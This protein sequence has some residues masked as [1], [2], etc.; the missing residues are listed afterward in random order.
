MRRWLAVGVLSAVL[1]GGGAAA[2]AFA[3]GCGGVVVPEGSSATASQERAI[4]SY[5]GE[6]ETIELT[7]DVTADSPSV[8]LIIPT[9]GVAS[10]TAGDGRTFDLIEGTIVSPIVDTV[11]WW[12]LGYLVPDPPKPEPDRLS[13]VELGPL[14][15]QSFTADDE[16][17]LNAWLAT[18][19][20]V[21]DEKTAKVLA[22]YADLGWSLTTVTL[23]SEKALSG[24]IDPIRLEFDTAQMVY[25]MR[26]NSISSTPQELRLYVFDQQRDAITLA[27]Q[28]TV[29]IDGSVDVVWSGKVTDS[30]LTVFGPYLTVFDVRYE[31]PK[32]DVNGDLG[33]VLSLVPGDEKP[34]V[35]HYKMVTLLGIPVG[36][37]IV[38]WTLLGLAIVTGHF[39][40]RRRAR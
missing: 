27:G 29:G 37:L 3:C 25:P 14:V 8:G 21:V 33:F 36:T 40:G 30:R 1:V 35:T 11:D 6:R 17:S 20:Y 10:V 31:V 39:V 15:A 24:H 12:G 13:R 5:D 7:I 16:E 9:P 2:P 22:Q 18:T 23:D 4:I 28:P 34:T 26:L 38:G 32:E 19:G